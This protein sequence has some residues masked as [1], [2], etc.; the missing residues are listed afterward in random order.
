MRVDHAS[1]VQIL[2][3][4]NDVSENQMMQ[5]MLDW[6]ESFFDEEVVIAGTPSGNNETENKSYQTIGE[7]THGK[8]KN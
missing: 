1:R 8:G 6:A 7:L 2:A 3:R 4:A 5:I